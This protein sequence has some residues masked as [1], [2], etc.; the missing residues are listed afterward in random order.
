MSSQQVQCYMLI[1]FMTTCVTINL[2]IICENSVEYNTL[3]A[4]NSQA[5]Q[6]SDV[7]LIHRSELPTLLPICPTRK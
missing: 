4:G 3:D 6:T 1:L 7:V 5:V 2:T